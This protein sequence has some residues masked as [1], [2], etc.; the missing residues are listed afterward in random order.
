MFGK[1][2]VE[3]GGRIFLK[4]GTHWMLRLITVIRNCHPFVQLG[5]Q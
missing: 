1:H 2:H 5:L 3:I 4:K